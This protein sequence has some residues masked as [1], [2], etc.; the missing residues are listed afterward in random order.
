MPLFWTADGMRPIGA[1]L[2][3]CLPVSRVRWLERKSRTRT[4]VGAGVQL[5]SS[6]QAFCSRAPWHLIL[7]RFV[8]FSGRDLV[9]ACQFELSHLLASLPHLVSCRA[10]SPASN[11]PWRVPRMRARRPDDTRPSSRRSGM[12]ARQGHAVGVV[13]VICF[14]L[15][16]VESQS[17]PHPLSLR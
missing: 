14:I 3:F 7:Q 17:R 12:C 8:C 13:N 16:D 11:Q 4:G 6:L 9:T 15:P 10:S 1:S 2:Q 5:L